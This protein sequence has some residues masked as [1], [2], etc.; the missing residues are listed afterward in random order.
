MSLIG[1]AFTLGGVDIFHSTS[2][3]ECA[4]S[5]HEFAAGYKSSGAVTSLPNAMPGSLLPS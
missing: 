1:A 2:L 4:I 3:F 5:P